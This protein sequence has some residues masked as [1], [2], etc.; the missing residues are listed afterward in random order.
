MVAGA[1]I[2]P[3][4]DATM[5]AGISVHIG[6][7]R[8]ER[9]RY[10]GV[11]TLTG[12]ENDAKAMARLA[13]AQGFSPTLLLGAKAT[14]GAVRAA[15]AAAA[16]P[17][18]GDGMVLVTYS[19]HGGLVPDV[20]DEGDSRDLTDG[21]D[22]TWCL[23]DRQML[24]D[25][26]YRMW[27]AFEPGARVLIVSDSCHSGGVIRGIEEGLTEPPPPEVRVR[28]LDREQV[29]ASFRALAGTYGEVQRS[30]RLEPAGPLRA[31][32]VLLAAAQEWELAKDG[33]PHGLF[34]RA[35][36]EVW[37]DGAFQGDYRALHMAIFRAMRREDGEQT[38]VYLTLPP[39]SQA[40]LAQR[41]FTI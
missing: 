26:I 1:F 20:P 38:P 36:L 40:F 28:A 30:L 10:P 8:L 33:H 21:N 29:D 15:V 19:G 41:P 37:N 23:W 4:H 12:C 13:R 25:E 32:V 2:H 24:D 14:V 9:T 18:G 31:S 39:R 35:L 22:E 7:N 27:T 11:C 34:T 3:N 5:P 6:V 17:V 16:S